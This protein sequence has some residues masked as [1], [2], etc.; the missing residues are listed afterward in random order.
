VTVV[1]HDATCLAASCAV[2]VTSVL[3]SGNFEPDAGAHAVVI[4]ASP[5]VTTGLE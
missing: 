4:G 2:H 1:V 3:P 5:P